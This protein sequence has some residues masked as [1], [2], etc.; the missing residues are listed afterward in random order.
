MK[1]NYIILHGRYLVLEELVT[2]VR[3]QLDGDYLHLDT[4]NWY[5]AR[6]IFGATFMG[7]L[8][9][10]ERLLVGSVLSHLAN[11]GEVPLLKVSRYRRYP[12]QNEVCGQ[13]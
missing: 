6:Q 5:T 10:R 3:A 8:T 12:N 9:H 7:L 4:G 13:P 2:C 1:L 11:Q